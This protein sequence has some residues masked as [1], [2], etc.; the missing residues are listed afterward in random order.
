VGIV[1]RIAVDPHD[2]RALYAGTG[3][4][5][6]A[7]DGLWKSTDGGE[8]WE[9]I[10]SGFRVS[11]ITAVLASAIPGR[12]YAAT[13]G[14]VYRSDDGGATW[15][16]RSRALGT[17]AVYELEADPQD[18]HRIFAATANGVWRLDERD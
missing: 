13:F 8:T 7:G 14:V 9:R 11:T 15:R 1:S 2:P 18:P 17:E 4:G 3:N 6:I 16:P 10:D 12:V 5:W